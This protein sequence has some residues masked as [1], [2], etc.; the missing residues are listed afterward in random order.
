MLQQ[1]F[2]ERTGVNLTGE[3]YAK[4]E[5]IYN[6]VQM[7]KDE[8][9][10]LWLKNKENKLI[11]ELMETISNQEDE[12]RRQRGELEMRTSQMA[13]EVQ[14]HSEE[15]KACE[16]SMRSQM[17]EFAKNIILELNSNFINIMMLWS[18]S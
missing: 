1:E 9:C 15:L 13:D 10:K 5:A 3:E 16:K 18:R 8:F 7:D 6:S 2:F 14:R 12:I 17:E 4:V 11:A